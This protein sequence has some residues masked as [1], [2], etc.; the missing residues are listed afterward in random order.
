[1]IDYNTYDFSKD[2]DDKD[3]R[4][5][6]KKANN[7][8]A[9]AM[10]KLG[11]YYRDLFY[12]ENNM[13]SDFEEKT[14]VWDLKA[15][16]WYEKAAKQGHVYA[17][18][19]IGHLYY[20]G[21]GI[22]SDSEK[23]VYWYREAAELDNAEAQFW[24]GK[25]YKN[26][27]GVEKNNEIAVHWLTKAAEQNHAIAADYLGECYRKGDGVEQDIKKAVCWFLIS[28]E[29]GDHDAWE[30]LEEIIQETG[31]AEKYGFISDMEK[32]NATIEQHK[33]DFED[34]KERLEAENAAKSIT[35]NATK[36]KVYAEHMDKKF[37]RKKRVGK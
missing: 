2:S 29:N 33:K 31:A 18:C 11:G 5:L 15:L 24:L 4:E 22:D 35:I 25:L 37:N 32:I 19:C 26:G 7:G 12:S 13:D 23:A 6:L 36:G 20:D 10:Y 28:D 30:K 1:M 16:Y 17:H 21:N 8:D 34:F 14:E 9:D 27:W 3:F